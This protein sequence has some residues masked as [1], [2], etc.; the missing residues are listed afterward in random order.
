MKGRDLVPLTPERMRG[1]ERTS[2]T[3]L[4]M[5]DDTRARAAFIPELAHNLSADLAQASDLSGRSA[6]RRSPSP[7]LRGNASIAAQ[8]RG[9]LQGHTQIRATS[10]REPHADRTG[11]PK[12]DW[13]QCQKCKASGFFHSEPLSR[14]KCSVCEQPKNSARKQPAPASHASGVGQAAA[15]PSSGSIPAAKQASMD[16]MLKS[17]G[18]TDV[19]MNASLMHKHNHQ[20]D[21]VLDELISGIG[22]TSSVAQEDSPSRSNKTVVPR[23]RTPPRSV[24]LDESQLRT[25]AHVEGHRGHA[26]ESFDRGLADLFG[27][28]CVEGTPQGVHMHAHRDMDIDFDTRLCML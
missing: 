13:W 8:M 23:P 15:S 6:D 16:Q 2:R 14:N 1:R 24:S 19:A 11:A 28:T 5:G 9:E 18:F 12:D 22:S 4:R 27:F 26:S 7:H 20:L 25:G 17:M 10:T 21:K 3:S